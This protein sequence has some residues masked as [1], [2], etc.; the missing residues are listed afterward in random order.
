MVNGGGNVHHFGELSLRTHGDYKPQDLCRNGCGNPVKQVLELCSRPNY[1]PG[2][3][4]R[5]APQN[6]DSCS[7]QMKFLEYFELIHVSR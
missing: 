3:A 5:F 1:Y 7:M 4:R 6:D 2:F